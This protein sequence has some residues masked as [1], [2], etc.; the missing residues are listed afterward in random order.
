MNGLEESYLSHVNTLMGLPDYTCAVQERRPYCLCPAGS[1]QGFLCGSPRSLW[2]SR[3]LSWR[4]DRRTCRKG[5]ASALPRLT[6]AYHTGDTHSYVL[7]STQRYTVEHT[8]RSKIS[9]HCLICPNSCVVCVYCEFYTVTLLKIKEVLY[10]YGCFFEALPESSQLSHQSSHICLKVLFT[11]DI[12]AQQP[13]PSSLLC[14]LCRCD[15]I[16]SFHTLNAPKIQTYS[17]FRNLKIGSEGCS[18]ALYNLLSSPHCPHCP[19]LTILNISFTVD[20]F[21]DSKTHF[22]IYY[23]FRLFKW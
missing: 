9:V 17:T 10:K 20:K 14:F 23:V 19:H 13:W 12:V 15:G 6:S 1:L 8:V 11:R 7:A 2:C 21:I 18:G 3:C 5:D 22:L 4:G 16:P